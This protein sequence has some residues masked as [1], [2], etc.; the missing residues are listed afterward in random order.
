[1]RDIMTQIGFHLRERDR[2]MPVSG[3][4]FP[5]LLKLRYHLHLVVDMLALWFNQG[6]LHLHELYERSLLVCRLDDCHIRRSR[7]LHTSL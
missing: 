5:L 1:M 3:L 2:R 4:L 7:E 6:R